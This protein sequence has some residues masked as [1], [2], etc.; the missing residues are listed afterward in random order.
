MTCCRIIYHIQSWTLKNNVWLLK[1]FFGQDV[2]DPVCKGPALWYLGISDELYFFSETWWFHGVKSILPFSKLI[3]GKSQAFSSP[4][5]VYLH[6]YRQIRDR[7]GRMC[8]PPGPNRVKGIARGIGG[9]GDGA[10]I[11]FSTKS[12]HPLPSCTLVPASTNTESPPLIISPSS[13]PSISN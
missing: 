2:F 13:F 5:Y 12:S 8:P 4:S 7:G 11:S 3:M 9:G 6:R 10:T 1:C